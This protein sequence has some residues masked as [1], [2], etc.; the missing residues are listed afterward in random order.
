[1][2][3]AGATLSEDDRYRYRLWR[4][5]DDSLPTV[6]WIM[7][8]PSTA[9]AT[10]DDATIR[11]CIGF[12]K[13]WGFGGIEVANLFAYRATDPKQ[14]KVISDPIGPLNDE[15]LRDLRG[16]AALVIAAW[17]QHGTYLCRDKHVK[18]SFR[19]GTGNLAYLKL[20][21]GGHPSHPLYLKGDLKPIPWS[22]R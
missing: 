6:G 7:L 4:R 17:G 22:E 18:M 2:I 11:R 21:K 15:F 10:Q 1:M 3:D 5:W 12:A 13:A 20:T 14:L 8:N 19:M 16:R 9:D